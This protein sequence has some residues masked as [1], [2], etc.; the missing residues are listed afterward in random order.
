MSFL[1]SLAR[2]MPVLLVASLACEAAMV[3]AI[4][5]L[6][7]FIAHE[8]TSITENFGLVGAF[9]A[10]L[11]LTSAVELLLVVR[12]IWGKDAAFGGG[13]KKLTDEGEGKELEDVRALRVTGTKKALVFV[14][15][16]AA[17]A[18]VFDALGDGVLV[19]DTRVY[20]VLS[21]WRSDDAQVRADAVHDAVIL[22][23]DE[24]VARALGEVMT[25]DGPSREW[26]AYAAGARA[27]VTLADEL[28]FL[29][30]N[31]DDRERA[32]AAVALARIKEP[33]LAAAAPRVFPHM[34][35]LG[36]DLV[37]ALGMLGKAA[38]RD[39]DLEDAGRLLVSL[40]DEGPEMRRLAV[41]ALGR[42]ESPRGLAPLEDMLTQKEDLAT[43]CTVITALG[44]MASDTTPEKF[45]AMAYQSDPKQRCPDVVYKDFTGHEVLLSQGRNLIEHLITEAGRIG[46]SSSRGDMEKIAEDPRFSKAVRNIAAE[47]AF[48]LKYRR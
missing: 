29:L 25:G 47:I 38:A 18:F 12:L 4:R 39:E 10:L 36:G 3:A 20:R 8:S 13:A 27:D 45:I 2:S 46:A 48:R 5:P 44:R 28:L 11:A 40:L 17:N 41:W 1:H 22:T 31:G 24:R 26:A 6:S 33:R 15:L 16:I 43:A 34:E 42:L 35:K 7:H 32:A 37:K 19:T 23:G 14:V 21:A 30:E 9:M